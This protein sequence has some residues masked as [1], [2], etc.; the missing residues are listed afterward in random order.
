[1]QTM[2]VHT[3]QD[4]SL[5]RPLNGNRQVNQLHASRIKKSMEDSVLVSPIIVNENYE[6]IDGQ[7][8]F[9]ALQELGKPVHY[10]VNKGYGLRE[11]QILNVNHKN[12]N[13]E[14]F[15]ASYCDLGYDDYL[16]FRDFH[17][18][19]EFSITASLAIALNKTGGSGGNV[20]NAFRDGSLEF[21]DVDG[22]RDRADR[23]VMTGQFFEKYTDKVYVSAMISLFNNENF[24]FSHFLGKLKIQPSAL[25]PQRNIE[26]YKLLI[27]DIYNYKSRNK[28]SLRY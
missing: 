12:W 10:I 18:G 11:T 24:E 25:Q 14:A 1:M 19:Y 15:L 22:A 20:L 26:Q 17:D 23:I 3:T 4:H 13:T 7:H 27:E 5:F 8:R 28:V 21:D 6:I 2:Q 16:R 9:Q